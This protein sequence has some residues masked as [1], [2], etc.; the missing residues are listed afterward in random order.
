MLSPRI[1]VMLTMPA[2]SAAGT[3]WALEPLAP[4]PASGLVAS[5]SLRAQ[6]ADTVAEQSAWRLARQ[7]QLYAQLEESAT[8]EVRDPVWAERTE[9]L[10]RG[11]VH[12]AAPGTRLMDVGCRSSL[13]RLELAHADAESQAFAVRGLRFTP[14][15]QEQLVVR[16]IQQG[17]RFFSLVY[18]AREGARLPPSRP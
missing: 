9:S 14:G 5:V 13:C 2:V 11:V 8:R 7:E 15:L 12:A 10:I 3:W 17:D 16:Q 6:G 1:I 4:R 18:A